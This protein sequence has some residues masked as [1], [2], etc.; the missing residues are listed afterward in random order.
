MKARRPSSSRAVALLVVIASLILISVTMR[1]LIFTSSLQARKV[2]NQYDRIQADYMAK[3]ALAIA[4]LTVFF[5]Y[6]LEKLN[7]APVDGTGQE[8]WNNPLPFPIPVESLNAL[9]QGP[10]QEE[11]EISAN[12][13]VLFRQCDEFFETFPGQSTAFV[14]DLSAKL[15]LNDLTSEA[16]Q[17]VLFNLLAPDFDFLESLR[18]RGI[19]RENLI[20]EIRDFID[21][22]AVEDES[23]GDE[24]T[25]YVNRGLDY[26]P[27]NRE[28]STIEELK[29]IPSMDEELF[30]YL[31]PFVS[32]VSFPRRPVPGKINLNTVSPE[33]FQALLKEVANPEDVREELEELR[34]TGV[35]VFS[36]DRLA[37]QI[38][39]LG[40][41]A[42]N[43]PM[44]LLTAKSSFFEVQVIAQVNDVKIERFAILQKPD[45]K[46]NQQA[47]VR[48][49]TSP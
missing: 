41:T 47:W 24:L 48:I 22:N 25:P 46:A 18:D 40:L 35:F 14:R 5:D 31:L 23:N 17:E 37:E 34:A 2:R 21:D 19:D 27:K 13:E 20:R 16:H 39:D 33:L 9:A 29:L 32:V 7:N 8:F 10:D 28:L 36:D 43:L 44:S 11:I 49:R 4:R 38:E 6:A 42:E 3:S 30:E 26:G 45:G 15:N 1:E 12:Q